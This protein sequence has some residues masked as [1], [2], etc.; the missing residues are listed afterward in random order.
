MFSLAWKEVSRRWSRA[1][2]SICGF[3][4]V[5]LLISAGMCLGDA[6]RRATTEPLRVTGADLVAF[7]SVTPCAFAPVKRPKDLGAISM[8]QVARIRALK[9][10]RSASG[11]LVVWA[12][13]EGQ[14]TVLTGVVPGSVKSGPLRQ[15]RS[16]D[17]CC[18]LEEG[19]RLFELHEKDAA[20]IDR[21]F[22]DE[23]GLSVGN[24]V[25]LG[26]RKF[27]VVGILKVAG[28]AVI[29]GGQAYAPLVTVQE[30]LGEGAVV[31]YVFVTAHRDA[32]VAHL[33]REIKKIIGQGCQVSSQESLPDQ[34]SR[35][36]AVTAAGTSAFVVLI[37][38]VGGLLMIRAA[39]AAV[40]ERVTEI[41][42]LRAIGWRKRHVVS[43]LG[44]E[45]GLQGM[46]GAVPG[47]LLGYGVAFAVCA[48]MN[49]SLPGSFNPYPPCATTPPA[50]TLTLEPGVAPGGVLVTFLLTVAIALLAG[51][52]CDN[53]FATGHGLYG[54]SNMG[55]CSCRRHFRHRKVTGFKPHEIVNH[56]LQLCL[57]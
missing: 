54:C 33:E 49:L 7:K 22:A 5:A 50:L 38:V 29:G 43:L 36:A 35:S 23:Q 19:G 52:A 34:I 57:C 25:P 44:L 37:L 12:F 28:V 32:D 47:I 53:P 42:I 6:I 17:R 3:L 27:N 30:M 21:R 16:G 18:V 1:V 9:G 20:V 2:L 11:S 45:M 4:L 14:P 40:R 26:P 56:L 51:I 13:N 39:L 10:V 46:L 31:T 55:G 8:E 48:R 15:Y 41:G 24:V